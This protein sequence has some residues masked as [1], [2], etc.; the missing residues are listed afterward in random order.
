M[1][2]LKKKMYVS[3]II[4]VRP[5]KE[6]IQKPKIYFQLLKMLVIKLRPVIKLNTTASNLK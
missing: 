4:D 2:L 1:T 5:C 6:V 3:Y